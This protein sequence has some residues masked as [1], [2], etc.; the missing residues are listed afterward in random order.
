MQCSRHSTNDTDNKN[1]C[2]YPLPTH[3]GQVPPVLAMVRKPVRTQLAGE[4]LAAHQREL[5]RVKRLKEENA[6]RKR[7]EEELAAVS[8]S[9]TIR[10][11]LFPVLSEWDAAA[12]YTVALTDA[13]PS[14]TMLLRDCAPSAALTALHSSDQDKILQ[15]SITM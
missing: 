10:Q 3:T 4:E 15:L 13:I 8:A 6:Q 12:Y 1:G 7:R 11:S 14:F 5:E 9:T 2:H